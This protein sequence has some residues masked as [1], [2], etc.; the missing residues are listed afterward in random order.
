MKT[1]LGL[2]PL[3]TAGFM[4]LPQAATASP[5]TDAFNAACNANPDFFA[6]AAV[7]LETSPDGLNRLCSCLTTSF[8][9]YPEADITMLTH[10]VEGTATAEERTAYGDYTALEMRAVDALNACLVAEGLSDSTE[11][12]SPG[13]PADMTVFDR[14]CHNSEG[15]LAVIGGTPEQAA[16]LRTTLCQ[17]LTATLGPQISTEAA[18]I[19]AMD[20][21]GTATEAARNAYPGYQELTQVAGAAFDGCFQT[22]HPA[23]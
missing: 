6:S 1:A 18:G 19:L 21:D 9:D 23:Q 22:L 12:V 2:L 5:A 8:A 20:L 13:G 16:P 4:A 11:A 17:C 14:A 7:G 3:L 15:L 10:D